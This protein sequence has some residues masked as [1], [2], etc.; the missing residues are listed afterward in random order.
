MSV[1]GDR[2]ELGL[3]QT[4]VVEGNEPVVDGGIRSQNH[5]GGCTCA[6]VIVLAPVEEGALAMV[7]DAGW[8]PCGGG[9][10]KSGSNS[11]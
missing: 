1:T 6:S 2:E 11:V 8:R 4:S 9:R 3:A 7:G 10:G 5:S